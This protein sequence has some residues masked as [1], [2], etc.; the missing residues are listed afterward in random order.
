MV[1]MIYKQ[2]QNM[3][4]SEEEAARYVPQM[5]AIVAGLSNQ[6]MADLAA[7]FEQQTGTVEGAQPEL[8]ELGEQIYRH[9][10]AETGVPACTSC[11][12]PDGAGVGLSGYPKL[13]GQ[14]AQY[15]TQQLQGFRAA[16]R[17]D[18]NAP[19]YRKNDGETMI[20]RLSAK[21][22]TDKQ[23]LAVSEYVS[24]LMSKRPELVAK[25]GASEAKD[26]ATQVSQEDEADSGEQA[27]SAE[28]QSI[29]GTQADPEK[30][31]ND[32]VEVND[33]KVDEPEAK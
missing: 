2:L 24:G 31:L 12:Q 32:T 29:E 28:E 22:L 25:D 16:A 11:H 33:A 9:G 8:L 10:M 17:D 4:G 30:P 6:D 19:Y 3:R 18:L 26:G 13:A 14:Y 7:Y 20:M 23:I 21:G 5:S 1:Q 27:E 15:T